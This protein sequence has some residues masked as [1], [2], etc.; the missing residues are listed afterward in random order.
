MK[1]SGPGSSS[2]L[3]HFKEQYRSRFTRDIPKLVADVRQNQNA[4]DFIDEC[5]QENDIP[6]DF[7][8][9]LSLPRG[10]STPK[11]S[12]PVSVSTPRFHNHKVIEN[13]A[14][15]DYTSSSASEK[16]TAKESTRSDASKTGGPKDYPLTVQ[17]AE[18][19]AGNTHEA[20]MV[21]R[22]PCKERTDLATKRNSC[23]ELLSVVLEKNAR[24]SQ[25][26]LISCTRADSNAFEPEKSALQMSASP[27]VKLVANK[28]L[29]FN[30][31]E[32]STDDQTSL[33][34]FKKPDEALTKK[35]ELSNKDV[36]LCNNASVKPSDNIENNKSFLNAKHT[37]TAET[38]N[39]PL[40]EPCP[41]KEKSKSPFNSLKQRL[42]RRTE[43]FRKSMHSF[44]LHPATQSNQKPLEWNTAS[45]PQ[46]E[47]GVTEME[48]EFVIEEADSI[49]F[50]SWPSISSKTKVS[51]DSSHIKPKHRNQLTKKVS[52]VLQTENA[53][54]DVS[55]EEAMK[56]SSDVVPKLNE[57]F[58]VDVQSHSYLMDNAATTA[59]AHNE[60]L[61]ESEANKQVVTDSAVPHCEVP[62]KAY[63]WSPDSHVV[64]DSIAEGKKLLEKEA[65]VTIEERKWK[66]QKQKTGTRGRVL[67]SQQQSSKGKKQQHVTEK[68]NVASAVDPLWASEKLLS[69]H[70]LTC[71][72]LV[73]EK[74]QTDISDAGGPEKKTRQNEAVSAG[75]KNMKLKNKKGLNETGQPK[76]KG[77][78]SSKQK[79]SPEKPGKNVYGL[80]AVGSDPERDACALA[81]S[82]TEK[83]GNNIPQRRTSKRISKPV[84]MWW[85]C[86]SE[87]ETQELSPFENA[88]ET[89]L[90]EHPRGKQRK[91]TAEVQTSP[92]K[93]GKILRSASSVASVPLASEE[94]SSTEG[95]CD[96]EADQ[97][98]NHAAKKQSP[99]CRQASSKCQ[100]TT[101]KNKMLTLTSK[102]ALQPSLSPLFTDSPKNKPSRNPAEKKKQP[103]L[104]KAMKT[105]N[106]LNVKT[107]QGKETLE[108]NLEGADVVPEAFLRSGRVSKPPSAW[109]LVAPPNNSEPSTSSPEVAQARLNFASK[110]KKSFGCSEVAQNVTAETEA[111]NNLEEQFTKS[112][113]VG[114][115]YVSSAKRSA[116]PSTSTLQNQKISNKSPNKRSISDVT[117]DVEKAQE[118]KPDKVRKSILK[119][120]KQVFAQ[121]AAKGFRVNIANKKEASKSD[122]SGDADILPAQLKNAQPRRSRILRLLSNKST[123][124]EQHFRRSLATFDAAYANTPKAEKG[125]FNKGVVNQSYLLENS[126]ESGAADKCLKDL[127]T[128]PKQTKR[129]P[130]KRRTSVVESE[131]S[132]LPPAVNR[133]FSR[134]PETLGS[135]QPTS[136]TLAA[137]I[138]ARKCKTPFPVRMSPEY[139]TENVSPFLE[140]RTDA[141]QLHHTE[142]T[143]PDKQVHHHHNALSS[144][145]DRAAVE[146][147]HPEDVAK[148]TGLPDSGIKEKKRQ[149]NTKQKKRTPASSEVQKGTK[150]KGKEKG[151][152]FIWIIKLKKYC[153]CSYSNIEEQYICL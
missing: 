124:K 139:A 130:P 24:R 119:T 28:R 61:Q 72:P 37:V 8:A 120:S 33:T 146:S 87:E 150:K 78:R 100:S 21:D 138:D 29:S 45:L 84:S 52:K 49:I 110:K 14:S 11:P 129:T 81:V 112:D 62:E 93:T 43:H 68:E 153:M 126:T 105:E 102:D 47:G 123:G 41:F 16:V 48:E 80:L 95:R 63:H 76:K 40:S 131:P 66:K 117:A 106:N 38:N 134:S 50:K 143:V 135:P 9:F 149:K 58:T 4:L 6:D 23:S 73:Q 116:C 1:T 140:E 77:V 145:E 13:F 118:I 92:A 51:K 59:K 30:T 103:C 32:R 142:E 91:N 69:T 56:Y 141:D 55:D 53:N 148:A 35:C 144:E 42:A 31:N 128:T 10:C 39:K 44:S 79:R 67:S 113:E 60:K 90:S 64:V 121:D 19:L 136:T 147:E 65:S 101:E 94:V 15:S 5:F 83:D 27:T 22:I 133:T 115:V 85:I 46:N 125:P 2:R 75:F 17:N 34:R 97:E 70:A 99:Q 36:K 86:T 25:H 82:E 151:Y 111:A 74:L 26:K 127:C 132:P 71:N 18:T 152:S 107:S 122:Q 137:S 109:W 96:N 104:K 54:N 98:G 89:L 88:H 3:G 12:I 57:T 20:D 114:N 7:T 108:T